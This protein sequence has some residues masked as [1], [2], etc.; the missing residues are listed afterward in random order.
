[1][2]CACSHSRPMLIIRANHGSSCSV[3]Q[4]VWQTAGTDGNLLVVC[5]V[6]LLFLLRARVDE[7][8]PT[9]PAF[10]LYR[11]TKGEERDFK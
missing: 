9:Y 2:L 6:F 4:Q 7:K 1:M 11:V 5:L 8:E 10:G 3:V